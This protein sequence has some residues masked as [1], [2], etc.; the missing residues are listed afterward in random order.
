MDFISQIVIKMLG[1][2]VIRS[3]EMRNASATQV[4][5]PSFVPFLG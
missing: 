4:A 1:V 5:S 2:N 3:H